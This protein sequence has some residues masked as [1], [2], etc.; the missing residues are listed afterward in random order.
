VS[1]AEKP[2]DSRGNRGRLFFPKG[3][4]HPLASQQSAQAS[5][6][7][8]GFPADPE[9]SQRPASRDSGQPQKRVKVVRAHCPP[10]NQ[11]ASYSGRFDSKS[12]SWV[13]NP[14]P[15]PQR[16]QSRLRSREPLHNN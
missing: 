16:V 9:Q 14:Y 8:R 13:A 5:S 7:G 3:P 1:L 4:G 12:L 6:P 10:S 2:G 11:M 15:G